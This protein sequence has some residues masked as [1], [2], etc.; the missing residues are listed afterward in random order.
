MLTAI[1][2]VPTHPL[3][4]YILPYTNTIEGTRLEVLCITETDGLQR[5]NITIVTVVCTYEGNWYPNPMYACGNSTASGI[6]N[7]YTIV[8]LMHVLA[9]GFYFYCY[10]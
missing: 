9:T 10:Y 4:G 3:N 5:E 2:D 7:S 6:Y 8:Q 1:C